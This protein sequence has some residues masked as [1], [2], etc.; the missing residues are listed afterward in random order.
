M[1]ILT[2]EGDGIKGKRIVYVTRLSLHGFGTFDPNL[3]RRRTQ[4][5]LCGY[6]DPEHPEIEPIEFLGT[7]SEKW[8]YEDP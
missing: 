7:I 6:T 8:P 3:E 4:I 1:T 5:P 2:Q